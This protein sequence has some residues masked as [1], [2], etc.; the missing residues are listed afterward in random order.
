MLRSRILK[1]R[2]SCCAF[3]RSI[4][5]EGHD[6]SRAT[7]LLLVTARLKSRAIPV[8]CRALIPF[9]YFTG[10]LKLASPRFTSAK[11]HQICTLETFFTYLGT[12]ISFLKLSPRKALV[13]SLSRR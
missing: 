2:F 11:A 12:V 7:D 13:L 6:F 8:F 5:R 10:E 1:L 3:C 9:F 4:C